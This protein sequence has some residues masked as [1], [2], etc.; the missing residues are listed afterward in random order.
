LDFALGGEAAQAEQV[1]PFLLPGATESQG[2]VIHQR[3]PAS[4]SV[5][6]SVE[7]L[8]TLPPSVRVRL[9]VEDLTWWALPGAPRDEAL[10]ASLL[11]T[12]L[13]LSVSGGSFVSAMDPPAWAVSA[14]AACRNVRTYP[15]LAGKQGRRDLLL[16]TPVIL[17]DHPAVA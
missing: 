15:V 2:P 11:G 12:H 6:V 17:P 9:R 13:L 3:W 14:V 1:L 8:P 7:P 4:G 5:R 16:S 10:R